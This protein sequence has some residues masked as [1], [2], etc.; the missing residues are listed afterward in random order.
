MPLTILRSNRR[1]NR[2]SNRPSTQRST[3]RSTRH[4]IWLLFSC[5]AQLA[6]AD[7]PTLHWQLLHSTPRLPEHFT[8]GLVYAGSQLFESTGRYG[9]S[10]LIAYDAVSLQMQQ[11][12]FLPSDIFAE[13][14]TVLNGKLYQSSWKSREIFVY[15]LQMKRLQTLHI[16][17]DSWGLT[18]DGKLLIMSDGSNTLQFLDPGD[19]HLLRTLTVSDDSNVALHDINEL[20]WLDGDILAN[21]WHRDTVLRID[22]KTGRVKGQY[23]LEKLAPELRKSMPTRNGEQVLNGLAWNPHTQA[24]LVTGKDWP[25]WFAIRLK[26]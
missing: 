3:R 24:L 19:G 8:E 23:N 12:V 16:T 2:G 7:V 22:S 14:L 25:V 10:R 15:D 5:L 9:Q 21:V 6:R 1:S 11:Q 20:E 26:P 4:A 13:G 18:T 17:G